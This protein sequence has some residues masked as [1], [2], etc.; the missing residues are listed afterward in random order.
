MT[1]GLAKKMPLSSGN[2]L[3]QNVFGHEI[4]RKSA[5]L[6]GILFASPEVMHRP[7]SDSPLHFDIKKTY[8][9]GAGK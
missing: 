3:F 5:L 9:I 8:H 7:R 4:R 2:F 6:S 1:S